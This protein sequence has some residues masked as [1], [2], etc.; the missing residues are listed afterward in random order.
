MRKFIHKPTNKNEQTRTI[1]KMHKHRQKKLIQ[2]QTPKHKPTYINT[3]KHTPQHTNTKTHTP[4]LKHNNKHTNTNKQL[5]TSINTN[6]LNVNMQT[7][8][9]KHR[10]KDWHKLTKKNTKNKHKNTNTHTQTHTYKNRRTRCLLRG[11]EWFWDYLNFL[12]KILLVGGS[13]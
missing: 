11:Y 10:K 8:A 12:K 9:Y 13:P 7:Q 4:T 6:T 3:H 2:I 5:T 1:T